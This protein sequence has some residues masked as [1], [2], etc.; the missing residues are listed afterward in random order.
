MNINHTID[1]IILFFA[2]VICSSLHLDVI[3][4]NHAITIT[5]IAIAAKIISRNF[6]TVLFKVATNTSVFINKFV[7]EVLI[8]LA[9]DHQ[10]HQFIFV[11]SHFTALYIVQGIFIKN[12]PIALYQIDLFAFDNLSSSLHIDIIICAHEYTKNIKSTHE[13]IYFIFHKILNA[14]FDTLSDI[15]LLV[16]VIVIEFLLSTFHNQGMFVALE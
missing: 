15:S 7:V 16:H 1:H 6:I 5:K 3:I 13:N 11:L 4:F 10:I 2:S 14:T 8:S 9:Q 12:K